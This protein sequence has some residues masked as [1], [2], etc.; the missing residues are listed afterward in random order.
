MLRRCSRIL[1]AVLGTA[2]LIGA[3]NPGSS[4]PALT[5]DPAGI[6]SDAIIPISSDVTDPAPA[7]SELGRAEAISSGDA[8]LRQRCVDGIRTLERREDHADEV[9][10][11]PELSEE[12]LEQM[13][14]PAQRFPDGVAGP[15]DRPEI[16][17]M[18]A[19]EPETMPIS[20][21]DRFREACFE[22]G[23]VSDAELYGE[24]DEDAEDDWCAELASF[25]LDEV[26]IFAEEE[27]DDVVREAFAACALPNPLD[28]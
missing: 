19:F 9:D 14:A 28:S 2:S 3:C 15:H 8:R 12:D 1:I 21:L 5:E 24:D 17:V 22:H 20:Q 23:L 27:G 10:D 16:D 6:T 11:E 25:P 7:N 4:A 26:R 13:I 18:A